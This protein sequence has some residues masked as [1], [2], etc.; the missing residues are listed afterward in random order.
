MPTFIVEPPWAIAE[1]MIAGIARPAAPVVAMPLRSVRREMV[2]RFPSQIARPLRSV[3][4]RIGH[5]ERRMSIAGMAISCSFAQQR[6]A[7]SGRDRAGE[8]NRL[9]GGHREYRGDKPAGVGARH[10]SARGLLR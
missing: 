10:I 9:L 7:G 1:R 2:M 4:R 3:L 8:T 6:R 5:G